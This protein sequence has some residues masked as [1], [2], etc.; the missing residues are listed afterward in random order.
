MPFCHKKRGLD[1]FV[2]EWWDMDSLRMR[3]IFPRV[4]FKSPSII[5]CL[6]TNFLFFIWSV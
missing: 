6:A 3:R 2:P 1:V 4:P 5:L